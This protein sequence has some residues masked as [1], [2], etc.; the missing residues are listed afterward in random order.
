MPFFIDREGRINRPLGA[1]RSQEW[2]SSYG[3]QN[4]EP[5]IATYR[6]NVGSRSQEANSIPGSYIFKPSADPCNE[7]SIWIPCM[8]TVTHNSNSLIS[9]GSRSAPQTRPHNSS[10]NEDRQLIELDS[11][12]LSDKKGRAI[13]VLLCSRTYRVSILGC[14]RTSRRCSSYTA[15]KE[16]NRSIGSSSCLLVL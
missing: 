6:L 4:F 15:H 13:I 3:Q 11:D 16:T 1:S 2:C 7:L 12:A 14:R 10:L 9:F 8:H 5:M